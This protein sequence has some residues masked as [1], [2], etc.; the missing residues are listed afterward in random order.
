MIAVTVITNNERHRMAELDR[1][2]IP[3]NTGCRTN[4]GL[5]LVKRCRRR[6]TLN[7]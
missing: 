2:S 3:G 4:S 5:M 6:L 7:H 1:D